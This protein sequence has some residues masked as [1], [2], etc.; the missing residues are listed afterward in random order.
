MR[1]TL[2]ITIKAM[3]IAVLLWFAFQF[4]RAQWQIPQAKP[5]D[6]LGFRPV[7]KGSPA[8]KVTAVQAELCR[9]GID[10][11]IDGNCGKHTALGQCELLVRIEN[12][13]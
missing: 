11:A 4:G 5:S 8:F 2:S 6:L 12:G 10:V 3:A 1:T 7:C 13:E 9:H